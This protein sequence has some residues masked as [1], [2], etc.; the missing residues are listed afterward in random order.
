M[1]PGISITSIITQNLNSVKNHFC[2]QQ[3]KAVRTFE[4]ILSGRYHTAEKPTPFR[5][6][7][8]NAVKNFYTFILYYCIYLHYYLTYVLIAIIRTASAA[9][10]TPSVLLRT[11]GDALF[12][13]FAA[14][15]AQTS[16][17]AM[18]IKS[19]LMSGIPPI[20]K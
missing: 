16:V 14:T 7:F 6:R 20:R 8:Q 3:T 19:S 2:P 4:Q 5:E 17:N 10:T 11:F 12:A 13:N 15:C 18:H 1:K 9:S